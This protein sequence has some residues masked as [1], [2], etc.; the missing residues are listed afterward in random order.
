MEKSWLLNTPY[1]EFGD[2]T[3]TGDQENEREVENKKPRPSTD[4]LDFCK[5]LLL[6]GHFRS[7]PW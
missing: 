2:E 7:V 3:E 6:G 5:F 1:L 4:Q